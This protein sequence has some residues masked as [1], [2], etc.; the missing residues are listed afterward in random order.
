MYSNQF[1]KS[2]LHRPE[3]LKTK[4][5]TMHGCSVT[6]QFSGALKTSQWS[7]D[8]GVYSEPLCL[9]KGQT[10]CNNQR[11][12][13][14]CP[15]P[16]TTLVGGLKLTIMRKRRLNPA[17]KTRRSWLS[18]SGELRYPWNIQKKCLSLAGWPHVVKDWSQG[19]VVLYS[20]ER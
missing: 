14:V 1:C 15:P 10:C 17:V 20:I 4:E 5:L 18:N 12:R 9:F 19:F 16:H 13:S 11:D 6:G 8:S 7:S 3:N 2:I